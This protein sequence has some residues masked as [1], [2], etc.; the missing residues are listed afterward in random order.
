MDD[1]L[2]LEVTGWGIDWRIVRSRN[3]FMSV[4]G[5]GDVESFSFRVEQRLDVLLVPV[6]LVPVIAL[7]FACYKNT[8]RS[9]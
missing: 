9:K 2:G 7:M 4:V 1:D 8:K 5:I 3:S 6:V